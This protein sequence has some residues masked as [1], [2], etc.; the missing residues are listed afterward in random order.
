MDHLRLWWVLAVGVVVAL[1]F[2][3][4]DHMWRSTGTFVVTL[5]GC[6]V[7]RMAQPPERAGGLVVRRHLIDVL[8]LLLLAAAVG[9]IGFNLDLTALR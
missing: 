7:L 8:T 6:A 9:L 1:G 2:A 4:T 5:V 3:A